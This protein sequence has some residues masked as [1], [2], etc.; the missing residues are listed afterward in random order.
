[1]RDLPDFISD[2]GVATIRADESFRV[3][4]VVGSNPRPNFLTGCPEIAQT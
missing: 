4:D 2:Y 1:M 3:P